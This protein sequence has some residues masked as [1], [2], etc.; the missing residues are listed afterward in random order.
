M[1]SV[2]KA[3]AVHT[4]GIKLGMSSKLLAPLIAK[5]L[6]DTSPLDIINLCAAMIKSMHV[7]GHIT[8]PIKDIDLDDLIKVDDL[9]ETVH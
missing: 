3:D 6:G 8:Y 2:L 1:L 5:Q 7:L 4:E 9:K